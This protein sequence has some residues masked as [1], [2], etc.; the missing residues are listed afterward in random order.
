M[1]LGIVT[2]LWGRVR[3]TAIMGRYYD[4]INLPGVR[5]TKVAA[6]S[7]REDAAP[8]SKDWVTVEAPNDPRADKWNAASEALADVRPDAVMIIGSDDFVHARH[9]LKGVDL[10]RDGAKF[11]SPYSLY[12]FDAETR[13]LGWGLF[14]KV[15]AGRFV[16]Y[17]VCEQY[18]WKLW[19]PGETAYMD[20]SMASRLRGIE[21]TALEG[22]CVL[23]VKTKDG[24]VWSYD[25]L[26]QAAGR[27][28]YAWSEDPAPKEW[29]S[30][31]FPSIANALFAYHDDYL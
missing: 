26:R 25:Y 30:V 14:S 16:S 9:I 19:V 21:V 4:A 18:E 31:E 28:R 8:L 23:D 6:Y 2:T 11:V 1:H 29:L 13:R 5:L 3:L 15:G 10:I 22:A 27:N 24:N 12:V 20:A 7:R 17:E